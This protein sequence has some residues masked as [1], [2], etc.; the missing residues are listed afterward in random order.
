MRNTF[1]LAFA[2]AQGQ[3]R[4]YML[5]VDDPVIRH[6][7]T[8]SL[9]RQDSNGTLRRTS[10]Q[11]WAFPPASPSPAVD[12]IRDS[13]IRSRS[14]SQVYRHGARRH[15]YESLPGRRGSALTDNPSASEQGLDALEAPDARLW[16]GAELELV[17]QQNS[18]IALV[19]SL[20][21]AALP[22]DVDEDS[23]AVSAFQFP[24][25]PVMRNQS[26]SSAYQI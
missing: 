5:S 17:C 21:Q 7:W 20:L 22:F 3:K 4:K 10:K 15:E 23:N 26:H 25:P 16:T 1:Q 8:G 11:A 6:E 9:K 12:A 13:H 24:A 14:R 18:A 19:L 2:D